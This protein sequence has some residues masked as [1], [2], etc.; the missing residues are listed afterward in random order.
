M[1]RADDAMRTIK[2]RKRRRSRRA[3]PQCLGFIS[4]Y[5]T[6]SNRFIYAQSTLKSSAEELLRLFGQKNRKPVEVF[7]QFERESLLEDAM[8]P[9]A[10]TE[11]SSVSPS[12]VHVRKRT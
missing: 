8:T 5:T 1:K 6:S 10:A 9:R 3:P 2:V 4:S 11:S 7:V 12:V